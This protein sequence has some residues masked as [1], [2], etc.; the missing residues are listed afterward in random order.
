MN[1]PAAPTVNTA[2]PEAFVG[3]QAASVHDSTVYIVPPDATPE[4]KY[5]VGL[6]CLEAG[7]PS[8]A[9]GLIRDAI[10]LGLDSAEA[11]F[12]WVLALLSKRTLRDLTS[13]EHEQLKRLSAT[14]RT[15]PEDEWRVALDAVCRLLS[16][17][18]HSSGATTAAINDL[19]ALPPRRRATILR[20]LDLVLTGAKKDGVWEESRRR[21]EESRC[22]GQRLD[23]VWAYFHADPVPAR[24]R[25]PDTAKVVT[26]HYVHAVVTVGLFAATVGHLGWLVLLHASALPVLA[27]LVMVAAG[28]TAAR[29]GLDWRYRTQRWQARNRQLREA[30]RESQAP[31]GGFARGV[32]HSFTHYFG[33]YRPSGLGR[34]QWLSRSAGIR[35]LLRDEVVEI[36][37]ESRVGVRRVDWLI[38]FMAREVRRRWQAGTLLEYRDRYTVPTSAKT[39]CLVLAATAG[40][41]AAVVVATAFTA[42]P[43]WAVLTT[44]LALVSGRYAAVHWSHILG[45]RRRERE[46]T[47]E[48]DEAKA[49]REAEH[50]RWKA[51]LDATRPHEQEMETWLAHDKTIL[52]G[53][54]LDL[55]RLPWQDVIAHTFLQTHAPGCKK[56]RQRGGA[57]RYSRYAIRLFLVTHD[58]VRDF[59][60]ELDF[61]RAR[62]TWTERRNFRFDAVSSIEVIRHDTDSYTLKLTLS[63]GPTR[64]VG[65]AN[66]E[67]IDPAP[68]E[69][70]EA[71]S[72][73]N[74]DAAGFTTTLHILE[75]I[76]AEGKA[77]FNRRRVDAT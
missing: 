24:A 23:R 59:S 62:L 70:L 19:H 49:A 9:R 36:Y 3:V 18:D 33:T 10:D 12:H 57:W 46:E 68:E 26:T 38:R 27:Y 71:F 1:A 43:M 73:I 32:D 11:S 34:E 63:N 17:P 2:A 47:D 60:A 31:E 30:G 41:A 44:L 64:D 45:E 6:R 16:T 25:E 69:D 28:S 40:A 58:G 72:E 53:E 29:Q 8:K 65:I 51:K 54:A 75:G 37:R 48:R 77:W 22:A 21:A 74:L 14:L 20:H 67:G 42:S 50:L 76:A 7:A 66:A 55:Y 15:Y 35:R 61:E 13:E 39:R 56:A 52:L 5:T 4:Q